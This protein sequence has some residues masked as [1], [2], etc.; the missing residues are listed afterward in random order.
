MCRGLFISS[1]K[2]MKLYKYRSLSNFEHI[3]E[4]ILE[5]KFYA[6]KFNELNDPMEGAF[7]YPKNDREL[8]REIV[9]EKEKL[10]ICSFSKSFKNVLLWC[11]YADSFK[12]VCFEIETL[13]GLDLKKIEYTSDHLDYSNHGNTAR[14]SR[15]ALERKNKIWKYE[16]E[17][18]AFTDKQY[19]ENVKITAIYLGVRISEC[20]KLSILELGKKE[21]IPVFSTKISNTDRK[22][23]VEKDQELRHRLTNYSI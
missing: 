12:G 18:R 8:K 6:A 11:H 13:H 19:I 5:K 16:K 1:F 14:F 15:K 17:Y 20:M 4:I 21:S 22:A 9:S 7:Y 3:L 10:R 2:K 23:V